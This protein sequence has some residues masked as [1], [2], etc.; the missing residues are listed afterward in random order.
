VTDES[1]ELQEVAE[2]VAREVTSC[3]VVSVAGHTS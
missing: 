2:R 1:S 3:L